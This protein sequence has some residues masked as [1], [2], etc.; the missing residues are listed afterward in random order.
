MAKKM[1]FVPFLPS[2]VLGKEGIQEISDTCSK[3]RETKFF[4]GEAQ[5]L[6]S[7][8]ALREGKCYKA[9]LSDLHWNRIAG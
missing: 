1:N 2:I 8:E 5:Q 6:C 9:V 3:K 4:L 7:N